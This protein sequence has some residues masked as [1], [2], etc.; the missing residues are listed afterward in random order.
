MVSNPKDPEIMDF[1]VDFFEQS[2]QDEIESFFEK[3]PEEQSLVIDHNAVVEFEPSLGDD[4]IRLPGELR[5]YFE[6][7]VE[8]VAESWSDT[9]DDSAGDVTIRYANLD[10]QRAVGSYRPEDL[11]TAMT[12]VGQLEQVSDVN[13]VLVEGVFTCQRCGTQTTCV[14]GRRDD[15][16]TKPHECHGC[17]RQGPFELSYETCTYED[18]QLIR[19]TTPPED[20]ADGTSKL[21]AVVRGELAGEYTGDI[22]TRAAVTGVLKVS[23]ADPKSMEYPYSLHAEHIELLNGTGEDD[24]SEDELKV[25]TES[26]TPIEDL[27]DSILPGIHADEKYELIK[28]ALVLQLVGS[29]QVTKDGSHLRGDWHMRACHRKRHVRSGRVWRLCPPAPKPCGT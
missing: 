14:Q 18:N 13:P 25:L 11:G 28:E 8:V 22:G 19:V 9:W 29:A 12:V 26:D 20:G 23:D 4:L 2:Y 3:W 21:T 10:N 27:T 1:V 16:V 15:R 6:E 5:E 7:A 17:E 24:V